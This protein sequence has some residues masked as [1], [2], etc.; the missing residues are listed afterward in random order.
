MKYALEKQKHYTRSKLS[1]LR[2]Y[3]LYIAYHNGFS[4]R[5]TQGNTA[6][7]PL[8]FVHMMPAQFENGMKLLRIRIL[9]T[10][11]GQIFYCHNIKTAKFENVTTGTI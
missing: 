5:V 7:Y 2:E 3:H 4:Q 1:H 10:R 9:F 8:D 6:K 11:L